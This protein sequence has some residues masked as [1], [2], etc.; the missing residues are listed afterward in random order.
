MADEEKIEIHRGLKGIYFERSGTSFIDGK[1]GELRYRGYSIHDLAE[2][3]TFEETAYLLLHGDLPT[4]IRNQSL[5]SEG[6]QSFR[7]SGPA[8]AKHERQKLVSE[9]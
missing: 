2:N 7:H 5:F 6:V 4:P 3:S 1:R 9:R 8:D